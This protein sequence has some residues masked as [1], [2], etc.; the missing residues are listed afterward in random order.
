MLGV[1]PRQ[2]PVIGVRP[3][4]REI[5]GVDEVGD[6]AVRNREVE[7]SCNRRIA[8]D[9]AGWWSSCR[10]KRPALAVQQP[11]IPAAVGDDVGTAT[12][13][14]A[15]RGRSHRARVAPWTNRSRLPDG[16]RS[17]R[18]R[19]RRL[20]PRCDRSGRRSK[21][22]PRRSDFGRAPGVMCCPCRR[23]FPA[24]DRLSDRH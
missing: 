2:K 8:N 16:R 13:W 21:P 18:R 24:R 1:R 6:S 23:S 10:C 7:T 11:S 22:E 15:P 12:G 9:S 19:Q 20:Q 17:Q 14:R 4:F 3:E 5:E